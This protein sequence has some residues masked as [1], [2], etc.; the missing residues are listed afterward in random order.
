MKIYVCHSTSFDF[1]KRLYEPIRNSGLNTKHEIVLPHEKSDSQF[2]SKEYLKKCDLVIAEVSYPS[3]GQ[4]IELGWANLYNVPIVCI[5]K[6]NTK[7][8]GALKAVSN[9]LFEYSGKEDLIQ[10]LKAYLSNIK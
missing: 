9:N 8:S 2:N 4:G 5:Y 7:P 10:K 3:T 6:F 1:K